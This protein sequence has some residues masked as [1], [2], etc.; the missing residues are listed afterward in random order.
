MGGIPSDFAGELGGCGRGERIGEEAAGEVRLIDQRTDSLEHG[1]GLERFLENGVA[2][3][4]A[5]LLLVDGLEQAGDE[6]DAG[7]LMA[8]AGFDAAAEFVAGDGGQEDVGEDDV[9][10][11]LVDAGQ[12][13]FAFGG[14][15]D[16]ETLLAQD[17]FSHPLSVGTI[18][19]EENEAVHPVV[20]ATVWAELGW[21]G[22]ARPGPA[23]SGLVGS[24]QMAKWPSAFSAW[25][26]SGA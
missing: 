4:A 18:V 19:G 22:P 23:W 11:E 10:V 13:G 12:G 1:R 26:V 17:A 2:A 5:G 24:I 8:I 3:G 16:V 14:G 20:P 15:D 6:D 9:G 7:V 21:S 25:T